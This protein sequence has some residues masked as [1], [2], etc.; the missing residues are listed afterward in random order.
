MHDDIA[1]AFERR[2]Y[3]TVAD[4][5]K[6]LL[7]DSPQDPWVQFY[8]ARLQEATGKPDRA[9]QIYR[10]LL[11]DTA[12]PK[13]ALQ[14]RQGLER[15]DKRDRDRR[16]QALAEAAADPLNA[17][18]GF[19]IL[20]PITGAARVQA[21][22]GFAKVMQIDPQVAKLQLPGRTWQLYR[23]G[24]IGELRVY[25]EEL[26][27]VGIP[28]LWASQAEIKQIQIFRVSYFK[29]VGA[30]PVV[31][32][33]SEQDQVGSIAFDWSEV[34]QRVQGRLPIFEKVIDLGPW[35]KLQH[36]DKTQDYVQMCDLHLP[37]RKC[38][39]RICDITYQFQDSEIGSGT[40]ETTQN[41]IRINWNTLLRSLSENLPQIKVWSDF[42]GF[43]ET[44][45]DHRVPLS[46][47][48]AQID[49]PRL[50]GG[51]T[52]WDPAFHLYSTLAYLKHT[53]S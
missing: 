10:Q 3:R 16:K 46:R 29:S 22:Q 42:E 31:I 30:Q 12:M 17:E 6:P 23:T 21:A 8:A 40:P 34:T 50:E 43:A 5:L 38:I 32:C 9:T 49:L 37:E 51:E 1:A 36:K 47:L 18:P 14:A 13:L 53:R 33:R 24:T 39:L 45:L 41:T 2:D 48:N 35:R 15:I 19:L 52:H 28:T 44:A 7:K 25:G 11:R 26:Q 20:E 4:L 27:Q